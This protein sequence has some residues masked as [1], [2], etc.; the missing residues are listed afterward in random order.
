MHIEQCLFVNCAPFEHI[1]LNFLKQGVNVLSAINGGGKTTILSYIADAFHEIA[2]LHFTSSYTGKENQFYRLMISQDILEGKDY[3]IA[4]IR[5]IHDGKCIDYISIRGNINESDYLQAIPISNPIP[6][7]NI[8]EL[9][10]DYIITKKVYCIDNINTKSIFYNNIITNFPAYRYEKPAFLNEKYEKDIPFD[11]NFHFSSFL[12]NPIDVISS[13]ENHAAWILNI[14]LDVLMKDKSNSID[15]RTNALML[16]AR[17]IA[18]KTLNKEES[19]VKFG[20]GSRTSGPCRLGI[21][22]SDEPNYPSIFHMSS[23][24]KACFSIFTELLR[25]ADTLDQGLSCPGIVLIDEID[26]HLHIK[27]QKEIIPQLISLFPNIQFIV[28]S[29]SPFLHMGLSENSQ[30]S[31]QVIDLDHNGVVVPKIDNPLYKEVYDM[32]ISENENFA[33]RCKSLENSLSNIEKTIVITE[34][35]TDII[36]ILRAKEELKISDIDFDTLPECSQP[37]GDGDLNDLLNHLSKIPRT[38]TVIG[39]FDRDSK[40]CKSIEN[41]GVFKT[42][43]NNVYAFCIP[44]PAH[45]RSN[46]QNNISIEYLYSDDEIKQ[47][48]RNGKRLFFGSEFNPSTGRLIE[49]SSICLGNQKGRG[50]DKIIENNGGQAVYDSD[51]KN[52]LAKKIE[53]AHAINTGEIQISKVSWQNFKPLFDVIR[54]ILNQNTAQSEITQTS[55]HPTST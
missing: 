17:C 25:Q 31:S 23:G 49:D 28:S 27:L 55:S 22:I 3:C 48:L 51:D 21:Q 50:E 4:Y 24:E 19:V 5:F 44:L 35:K 32:M 52:I 47:K 15:E 41:E 18:A 7:Q 12:P 26:K 11:F 39:I 33:I 38:N 8:K 13:L 14:Y 45:R 9:G 46:G 40:T 43:G 16:N 1:H 42:Y 54:D 30:I 53:F 36:H 6:Y 37:N 20:I 2:K 34:G 10:K 29:H